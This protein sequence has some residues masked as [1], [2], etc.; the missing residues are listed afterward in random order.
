MGAKTRAQR[1]INVMSE[2]EAARA[3]VK[4]RRAYFRI[5]SGGKS[6]NSPPSSALDWYH[7]QPLDLPNGDSV[8]VCTRWALPD[9]LEGVTVAD[10]RAVQSALN[11]G[12]WRANPQAKDW[13]GVAAA[14]ALKLEVN[15]REHKAK[16]IRLLKTW[17]ASGM[18]SIVDGLDDQRRTRS[19]IEV[20]EPAN[21]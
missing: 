18:F 14:K 13:A 8:G 15:N 17:T 16:I 19:F 11:G 6:N 12:R 10:L 5:D 4:E 7:L 20:G 1:T 21:D 3:G 2:D 9:P